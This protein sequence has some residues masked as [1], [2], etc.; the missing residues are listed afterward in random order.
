MDAQFALEERSTTAQFA[1]LSMDLSITWRLEQQLVLLAVLMASLSQLL[2]T[3][4]ASLAVTS[5]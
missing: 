2:S 5:V 4:F 3:T 1:P